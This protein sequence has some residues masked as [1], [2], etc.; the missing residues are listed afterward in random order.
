MMINN[1]Q[2]LNIW[3]KAGRSFDY[4]TFRVA[5]ESE[6]VTPLPP[7][8]FAQKAGMIACACLAYPELPPGGAYLKFIQDNQQ[9]TI[10]A[11][12]Q[13]SQPTIQP[14]TKCCGGGQVR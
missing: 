3:M 8:E 6:G 13:V 5:C 9:V 10:Q 14:R 11:P 2:R 1:E 12:V 7:M 4:A